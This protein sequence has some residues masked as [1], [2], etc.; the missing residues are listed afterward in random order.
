MQKEQMGEGTR[1][2]AS[3]P[4]QGLSLVNRGLTTEHEALGG[5]DTFGKQIMSVRRWNEKS[6]LGALA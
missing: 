1:E 6:E 5:K 2:I 3:H 4:A